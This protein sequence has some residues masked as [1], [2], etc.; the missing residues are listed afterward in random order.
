M[1]ELNFNNILAKLKSKTK[2]YTGAL[3]CHK[4]KEMG[5]RWKEDEDSDGMIRQTQR[6]Y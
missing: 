1:L 2:L 6:I 3:Y 4:I 5:G